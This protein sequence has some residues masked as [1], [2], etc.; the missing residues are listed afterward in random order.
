MSLLDLLLGGALAAEGEL[1]WSTPAWGVGLAALGAALAWGLMAL[2]G[3]RSGGART[4]ELALWA[5]ALCVLVVALAGPRWVEAD[6]RLEPG[7]LVVLVDGSA[8]MGV[9]DDGTPRAA[10]VE[11]ALSSLRTL[12]G[13]VEVLTFDEEVRSGAPT[14]FAGRGS[15]LGVALR[16]VA[17]RN[18]GQQLQGI[19]VLTDGID[20]GSLRRGPPRGRCRGFRT[21]DPV[22][23]A[24]R[25]VTFLPMG[26]QSEVED[27]AVE[28][29]VSGALPFSARPSTSRPR[30]GRARAGGS[31]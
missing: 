6:G 25:S 31:R 4:A 20:Q 28:D 29:V 15:D 17:D 18:L 26:D 11:D 3:G 21:G 14:D 2:R 27:L 22:A 8:S 5:G 12:G 30:C 10:G 9:Q 19:V 7:K 23:Q 24:A 1:V 16:T 13:E